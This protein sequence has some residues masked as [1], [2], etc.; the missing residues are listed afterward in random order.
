MFQ[1]ELDERSLLAWAAAGMAAPMAQFLGSEPWYLVLLSGAGAGVLWLGV[2]ARSGWARWS[3]LGA[4]LQFLAASLATGLAACSAG[5]SW[6]GGGDE[7]A[8][9]LGL[10]ALS[11]W[12][13]FRGPAGARS[14][15][16][17]FLLSLLLYGVVLAFA[18]P[19][20]EPAYLLPE[21][22]RN[23][24]AAFA[25]LM[26][27]GILS[28]FPRT[29]ERA[30]AV[31]AAGIAVFGAL[32]AA[33]TAGCLSPLVAARSEGAFFK[34]AAGISILGIAE[35]F[36]AVVSAVM[37]MGWFCL[38]SLFLS[39]AGAMAERL[40]PGAGKWGVCLSAAV[41]GAMLMAG[42]ELP[43]G[44]AALGAVLAWGILPFLCRQ[45]NRG[46]IE[47]TS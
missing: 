42:A 30:P 2:L 33:V 31:W 21:A 18:L 7:A 39:A 10:L 44:A 5:G 45:K 3:K 29:G 28:C 23:G 15:P 37:T 43:A 46:K 6:R 14:G 27:P 19:D 35:R 36:E 22:G 26:V 25:I 24:S 12:A 16:V 47:K 38:M 40:R 4:V 34:M 41:A 9:G 32:V 20:V 8:V 1:K 13:S 11:A 17:V